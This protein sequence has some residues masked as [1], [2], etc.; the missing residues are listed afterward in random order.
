MLLLASL[1]VAAGLITTL[2]GFGG[3]IFL[4]SCLALIWDPLT[5]LTLSSLCLV[6]GNAQRLYLFRHEFR[7]RYAKPVILGG[8]PGAFVGA[9]IATQ[10]PAWLLQIAIL[11]ITALSLLRVI[12]KLRFQVSRA[13]LGPGAAAVGFLSAT[14]GGGGFLMGPLLLSAGIAGNTYIATGASAGMA[15]HS[16]KV[17]GYSTSGLINLALIG[18]VVLITCMIMIG[19]TAGRLI[20]DRMGEERMRWL[21][22]A[23]PALCALLALVGFF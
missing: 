11:T 15:M 13:A 23:A 12:L 16:F 21:E 5:A 3:G 17:I 14:T 20:R 8:I 19:N 10:A 22:Y 2:S 4:V 1:G 6:L 7:W 18:Q 9:R